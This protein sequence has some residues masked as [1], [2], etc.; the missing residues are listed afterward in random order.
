MHSSAGEQ[1]AD[2]MQHQRDHGAASMLLLPVPGPPPPQ[3]QQQQAEGA[4]AQ[5]EPGSVGAAYEGAPQP[6]QAVGVFGIG[7]G[8]GVPA[9]RT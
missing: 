9:R 4:A 3:Q 1:L 8:P 5:A 2:V 7:L 6:F